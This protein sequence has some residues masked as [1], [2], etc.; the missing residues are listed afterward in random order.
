MLSIFKFKRK[1]FILILL[2]SI[3]GVG[4]GFFIISK[5]NDSREE[6]QYEQVKVK[7]GDIVVGLDS[8]GVVEFSKVNLRFGVKGTI[9]DILVKEGD[10]VKK[11]AII[12]KLDDQDYQEEY[13]L[14]VAKLKDSQEEDLINLLNHELTLEKMK[15]E[16]EKLKEEYQE[17]TLIPEAYS[18][19]EIK[20]KK[21]DVENKEREYQNAVKK[22]EILV[23]DYEDNELNQNE[24]AVKIAQ[25]NLNDTIL[26][27]PVN[28]TVLK[29][30]KKIGESL[31]D[32]QDFAVIHENNQ[33][34]II[35]KVIEYDISRIKVGQKVNI[36]VEAIPD[37]KYVGEVSKID[38]LPTTDSSGLVS[39]QVEVDIKNPDSELKDGMT[40][41][42]TFV[43][44][45]V[46]N[47]LIIPYKAV[48]IVNGKQ[49]ATVIEKGEM[50]EKEIKT[51]FTDGSSVEVLEGLEVNE[52][53]L[54]TKS[55]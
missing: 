2:V 24:L 8:D 35:T 16:L 52:T 7:K 20:M 32:E 26:Y 53:V 12:A 18:V 55:R 48:K 25:E 49:L 3:L 29:L 27:S 54:Y 41:M 23:N 33:Y 42:V 6:I 51:G 34:K 28:G 36:T 47:A 39:Y 31:T 11:G 4:T 21:Q 38:A 30:A 10:E 19:S 1:I 17:M 50:V 44:K 43:L 46:N 40:C 14:A 5:K 45:E 22:H 15:S 9:A 37:K 13:Q